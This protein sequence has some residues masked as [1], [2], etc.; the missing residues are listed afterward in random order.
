[1]HLMNYKSSC[2]SLRRRQWKGSLPPVT[3]PDKSKDNELL[4]YARE[5]HSWSREYVAEQ[6]GAPEP[7]MVYTWEREG[8]LPHP[9]YRQ[10]LCTLFESTPRELGLVKKGEIPFWNVPYRRNPFFTGR[11]DTLTQLHRT[12]LTEGHAA[13]TQVRAISGLG[14]I[15]KTQVGIEYAYRYG[16]EYQSVFWV[17]A[18]SQEA[19]ISDFS[20]IAA[21]LR[22][23]RGE[24]KD[25]QRAI[26][27]VRRWLEALTHWLLILDNVE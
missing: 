2:C 27:A 23:T 17:R 8:V 22:L 3:E 1:M 21:L 5:Q 19:L 10:A 12:L 16:R 14:G 18:E 15:G 26:E 25:Q 13:I 4:E 24:T 11:E 9:H 6:I 20:A 7:R